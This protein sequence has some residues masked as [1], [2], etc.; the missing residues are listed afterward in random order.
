[1]VDAANRV[2]VDF[3][4]SMD[5]APTSAASAARNAVRV[6]NTISDTVPN[7]AAYAAVF[8]A[9]SAEHAGTSDAARTIDE[10]I[11]AV[12]KA[13]YAY[14]AS[15]A[16]AAGNPAAAADVA[17]SAGIIAEC[18]RDYDALL[19]LSID[20]AGELGKPIDMEIL[21]PLWPKR[22]PDWFRVASDEDPGEVSIVEPVYVPEDHDEGQ[23]PTEDNLKKLSRRGQVAYAVRAAERVRPLFR[24]DDKLAQDSVDQAILRAAMFFTEGYDSSKDYA[25]N[26]EVVEE[27]EKAASVAGSGTGRVADRGAVAARAAAAALRAT[28]DTEDTYDAH[29]AAV[30]AYNGAI[31]ADSVRNGIAECRGDFNSLLE[32]TG[33]SA[34]GL[35]DPINLESLGPLWPDGE[36]EWFRERPGNAELLPHDQLEQLSFQAAVAYA[37]RAALRVRPLFPNDDQALADTVDRAIEAA[38]VAATSDMVVS[39][40]PEEERD[41]AGDAVGASGVQSNAAARHAAQAAANAADCASDAA[42]RLPEDVKIA[43]IAAADHAW[44]A[45]SFVDGID[46]ADDVIRGLLRDFEPLRE[47]SI[48]S[49]GKLGK[50]IDLENLGPLWSNGEP[51]WLIPC[52]DS[53]LVFELTIP[54]GV[55]DE[56]VIDRAKE[57]CR[58]ADGMH[59]ALGGRGLKIDRTEI[60]DTTRV[61]EVVPSG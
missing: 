38:R 42:K 27:A 9:F 44:T 31:S 48:Y 49:Q 6:A 28:S 19:E 13:A 53:E 60:E 20:E 35:G 12:A 61:S 15:R 41:F 51:E 34:G 56:E 7:F 2:A 46:A 18:Q 29:S 59:R 50:P 40:V 36:P 11:S 5:A 22:E 47:Q 17:Y 1:M 55:S 30:L 43:A 54:E 37:W 4:K 57:I 24:S 52:G 33:K 32:L 16:N 58:L 10:T 23:L 8:S 26:D 14:R 45:A 3:T 25:T 39:F 21:G